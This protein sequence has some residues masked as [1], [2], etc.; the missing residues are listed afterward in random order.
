[1]SPR[2]LVYLERRTGRIVDEDLPPGCVLLGGDGKAVE[3]ISYR[4]EDALLKA[5][6]FLDLLGVRRCRTWLPVPSVN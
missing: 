1:M 5:L 3:G 6:A 4:P 2:K